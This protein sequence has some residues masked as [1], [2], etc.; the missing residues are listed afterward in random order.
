MSSH[1]PPITATAPCPICGGVLT[2]RRCKTAHRKKLICD[3]GYRERLP[4]SL[5]LR[6]AGYPQLPLFEERNNV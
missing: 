4:E 2:V 3:C 5:R 6:L 1:P